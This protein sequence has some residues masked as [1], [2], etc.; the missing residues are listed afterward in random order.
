MV[1]A[2]LVYT[3]NHWKKTRT[4]PLQFLYDNSRGFVLRGVR[5]GRPVEF[6]VHAQLGNSYNGFYSYDKRAE[7]WINN[8]GR[9][10][11]ANTTTVTGGK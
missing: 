2:D 9:N 1:S 4:A 7:T 11:T 5:P 8:G 3:T 6:A 10:Y